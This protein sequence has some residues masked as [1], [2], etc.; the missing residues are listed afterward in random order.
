MS[1]G[2]ATTV[3]RAAREERPRRKYEKRGL[4]ARSTKPGT[5]RIR[6]TDGRPL[7]R[8]DVIQVELDDPW[9]T[10]RMAG[11][12]PKCSTH[13]HSCYRD[14]DDCQTV[15]YLTDVPEWVALLRLSD[16][17]FEVVTLRTLPT[18]GAPKLSEFVHDSSAGLFVCLTTWSRS[19]KK[20][21]RGR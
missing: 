20:F 12:M 19:V 13:G 16:R 10:K 3:F 5:Y 1:S 8:R 21:K 6:R 7:D 15:L 2:G 18:L 11:F 4:E 9:R 14:R 17:H